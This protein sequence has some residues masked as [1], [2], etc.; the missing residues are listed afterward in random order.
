MLGAIAAGGGFGSSSLVFGTFEESLRRSKDFLLPVF[1][2]GAGDWIDVSSSSATSDLE[3][4][5]DFFF[6]GEGEREVGR[7]KFGVQD[8]RFNFVAKD[9][10]LLSRG[11]AVLAVVEVDVVDPPFF[12]SALSLAGT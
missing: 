7:E 10:L 11:L 12:S 2:L 5:R 4:E 8:L 1:E 6:A 3:I 9:E